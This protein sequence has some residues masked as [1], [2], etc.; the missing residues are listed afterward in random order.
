MLML[1]WLGS[2]KKWIKTLE[3][4]SYLSFNLVCRGT[5]EK[6]LINWF[7][8]VRG[9]GNQRWH[10]TSCEINININNS[11][12]TIVQEKRQDKQEIK[13][14]SFSKII[15]EKL[16]SFHIQFEFLSLND[17]SFI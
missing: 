13:Y 7:I 4:I 10:E 9:S 2:T 5:K 14:I 16:S 12:V 3:I 11:R 8:K 1:A 15:E 17:Q 6:E